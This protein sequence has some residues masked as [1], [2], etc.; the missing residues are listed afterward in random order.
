METCTTVMKVRV[1]VGR[2]KMLNFFPNVVNEAIAQNDSDSH[3]PSGSESSDLYLFFDSVDV[4]A[5]ILFIQGCGPAIVCNFMMIFRKL[6]D[7][8]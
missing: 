6:R 3:T 1:V 7:V 8:C 4:N 5:T 2:K